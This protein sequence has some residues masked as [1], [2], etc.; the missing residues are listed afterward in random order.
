[1]KG[2]SILRYVQPRL[3]SVSSANR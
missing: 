3:L 2:N 1:M